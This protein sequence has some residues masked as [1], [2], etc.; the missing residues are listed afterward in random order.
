MIKQRST[1]TV[2]KKT[3][4]ED[5][6]PCQIEVNIIVQ[7]KPTLQFERMEANNMADWVQIKL[8]DS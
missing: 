6:P 4:A 5:S 3:P 7:C 2:D 8:W 1:N